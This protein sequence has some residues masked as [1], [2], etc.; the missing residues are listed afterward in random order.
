MLGRNPEAVLEYRAALQ[1]NPDDPRTLN[2]LGNV[3]AQQGQLEAAAGCYEKSLR[4]EP[5]NP[6]TH[7]NYGLTLARLGRRDEAIRQL[8]LALEQRPDYPAAR[9]WLNSIQSAAPT[10]K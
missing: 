7:A 8:N 6:E 3:C 2:N 4:L 10:G 1:V 9:A 5:A